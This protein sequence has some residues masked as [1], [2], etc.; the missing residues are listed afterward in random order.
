MLGINSRAPYHTEG[1]CGGSNQP[2]SLHVTSVKS[3]MTC[4]HSVVTM[5]SYSCRTS[6]PCLER[7]M[8]ETRLV[9]LYTRAACSS[10]SLVSLNPRAEGTWAYSTLGTSSLRHNTSIMTYI[11]LESYL[12]K[13]FFVH[14]NNRHSMVLHSIDC[15]RCS[16][17]PYGTPG[18]WAAM[19]NA[20][21]LDHCAPHIDTLQPRQ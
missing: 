21:I 9:M 12:C 3:T 18:V 4:S 7:Y 15:S 8:P 10:T 1:A 17:T 6:D 13:T 19:D 11:L 2:R 5:P 16:H 20:S 14:Y